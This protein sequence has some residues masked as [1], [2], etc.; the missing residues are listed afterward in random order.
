MG[1]KKYFLCFAG[2]NLAGQDAKNSKPFIFYG[3][4]EGAS[5][6][7]WEQAIELAEDFDGE[8][9]FDLEDMADYYTDNLNSADLN[10]W[11]MWEELHAELNRNGH[12]FEEISKEYNLEV[13][14]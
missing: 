9:D 14:N 11:S 3:D 13:D 4:E 6:Y 2:V 8:E 5:H 12:T 7:A 1:S 10:N